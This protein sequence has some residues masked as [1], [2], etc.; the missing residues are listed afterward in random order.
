M[1]PEA[2]K[3]AAELPKT[4]NAK[5]MRRLIRAVHLTAHPDTLPPG[6]TPP[7]LGDVSALDNPRA[8]DAVRNAS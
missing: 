6:A 8:L 2:V 4:R 7:A 1:K 3:F 5:V